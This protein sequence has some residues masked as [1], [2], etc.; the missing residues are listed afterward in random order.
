MTKTRFGIIGTGNIAG[1]HAA[2]IKEA[3]NAE[4]T[5]VCDSVPERVQAFAEKHGAAAETDL[6]LFLARKDIDVVTIATPSGAHADVAVPAA[7]AGKHI[8]CEK[9]IEVTVERARSIIDACEASQVK[10]AC[11]FQARLN[12]NVQLIRQALD[13]GRFGRLILANAQ[14]KWFRSQEY[15]DSGQWR[16]TWALDGGGALMNQSIHIIDLLVYLAGPPESVFARTGTLTH[17]GIEVEDTAAAVIQFANGAMGTI[18]A[19]TSCAPGFPRRLEISGEKGSV[20]MED[21][22]LTRWSFADPLPEDEQILKEG[23]KGDNLKGGFA[24]PKAISHEGHRRLIED[25]CEAIQ[26]GREPAIPGREGLGAV[27]LICGIYDSAQT[28]KPHIFKENSP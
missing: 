26:N 27:E 19:S 13:A 5:A 2:A 7:R 17:S 11:V 14:V 4:L 20:V 28:G 15:Y 6:S 22:R 23:T 18:E 9:P 16:G 12:R 8:L 1:F 21:D 24:D 25:L 10:L 3:K